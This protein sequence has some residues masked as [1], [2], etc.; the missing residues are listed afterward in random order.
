MVGL[1]ISAWYLSP[2]TFAQMLVCHYVLL[3]LNWP[4][5]SA[6]QILFLRCPL[7]GSSL[8]LSHLLSSD[9]WS[10]HHR[11]I[12][13]F[14]VW[15]MSMLPWACEVGSF[16]QCAGAK[17]NSHFFPVIVCG[18]FPWEDE[19]G[20]EVSRYF[21][22][23]VVMSNRKITPSFPWLLT[24]TSGLS[25]WFPSNSITTT[26]PRLGW[27]ISPYFKLTWKLVTYCVRH[28]ILTWPM[29][30]VLGT[31]TLYKTGI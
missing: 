1:N 15:L 21:P 4:W 16:P 11:T 9:G 22:S 10:P 8:C 26:S 6:C 28:S 18:C 23:A 25:C 29:T 20:L 24:R 3:D 2:P 13:S 14:Y 7:D 5:H 12:P 19:L 31:P 27:R 30:G 17:N